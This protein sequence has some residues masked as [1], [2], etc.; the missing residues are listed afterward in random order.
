L[1]VVIA[2]L[3]AVAGFGTYWWWRHR[4]THDAPHPKA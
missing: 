4:R 3:V 1:I 2:N